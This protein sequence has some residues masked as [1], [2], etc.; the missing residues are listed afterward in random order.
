LS[1][2]AHAQS[3]IGDR[4]S[5]CVTIP[6]GG[7]THVITLTGAIPAD[8]TALIAAGTSGNATFSGTTDSAGNSW[9]STNSFAP[10]FRAF[11][12][13]GRIANALSMSQTI[14][15]T[16]S[17]APPTGQ[18]SCAS[19]SAFRAVAISP[20]PP[21][22]TTGSTTRPREFVHTVFVIGGV[23]GGISVPAP[24]TPLQLACTGGNFCVVPA[25]RVVNAIGSYT[26]SA[27]LGNSVPWGG[28][29]TAY[30]SDVVFADGFQ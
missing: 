18:T 11:S 17:A 2:A 27:T 19:V 20:F 10:S 25:Y 1:V 7:G 22:D 9:V 29:I 15:L 12:I 14:T 13:Y 30:F 4:G 26:T 28:V 3:L 6:A 24:S 21:V 23:S 5:S 16:Y 8:S